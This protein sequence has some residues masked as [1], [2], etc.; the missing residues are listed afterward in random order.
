[1]KLDFAHIVNTVSVDQSSDLFVAQ[2]I[3]FESMRRARNHAAPAIR[4]GLYTAQFIKDAPNVPADF[5]AAP[6]LR[7][8]VLDFGEFKIKRELPLLRDILQTLE[9]ASEAAY[10]I[11]TN[12]DIGLQPNFYERVSKIILSGYDSFVIN[13]R[14]VS[15]RYAAVSDLEAIYDDPGKPHRGWDCFVFPSSFC[16]SF[17]LHNECIGASR[18]GLSLLSNLVALSSNFREFRNEQ[19][20]FHIGDARNWLNPDYADYD[21]HNTQELMRTLS[22]LE[23]IYGPFPLQSIPGTFLSRKRALGPLYDAW[24]RNIYLPVGISRLLNRLS[25]RK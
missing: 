17:R 6:P 14:T 16:R 2:P 22:D 15:D 13:R 3:T 5:T 23:N 19:L 8:S 21:A 12:V 9:Q 11:Y 10:F 25:G 20:T 1:M 7:R 4:V 24:S 18:V